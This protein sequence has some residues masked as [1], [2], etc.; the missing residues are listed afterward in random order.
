MQKERE[1]KGIKTEGMV[2]SADAQ[3]LNHQHRSYTLILNKD[4]T[5]KGK[6]QSNHEKI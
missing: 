2:S 6:L 5:Q 1:G 3:S 4:E